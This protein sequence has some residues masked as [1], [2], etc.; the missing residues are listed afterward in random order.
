MAD[1]L[2]HP[3]SAETLPLRMEPPECLKDL[4]QPT[5]LLSWTVWPVS[6]AQHPTRGDCESA[7]GKI[8]EPYLRRAPSQAALRIQLRT[9][10]RSRISQKQQCGCASSIS[11]N[12]HPRKI[13]SALLPLLQLES[14][15]TSWCLKRCRTVL[16][17]TAPIVASLA[18]LTERKCVELNHRQRSRLALSVH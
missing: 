3:Q 7:K 2:R 10:Q 9:T 14:L 4:T 1:D 11:F 5:P 17:A 6:N 8:L 12:A 16:D 15:H 18:Y 13:H